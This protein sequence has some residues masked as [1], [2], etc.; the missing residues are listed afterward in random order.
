LDIKS[1][2]L[3]PGVVVDTFDELFEMEIR[4]KK[5]MSGTHLPQTTILNGLTSV[6]ERLFEVLF[7]G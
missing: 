7:K 1:E 4:E 2:I 6:W 5:G 3:Q